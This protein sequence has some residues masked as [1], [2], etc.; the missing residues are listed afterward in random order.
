MRKAQSNIAKLL[1]TFWF[2]LNSH[3]VSY[4]IETVYD[5]KGKSLSSIASTSVSD[6][7]KRHSIKENFQRSSQLILACNVG[8]QPNMK[9]KNFCGSVT[10][11]FTE[12]TAKQQLENLVA[13]IML[14]S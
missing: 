7:F 10:D 5:G 8:R 13:K 14:L 2:P 6:R 1:N 4:I 9:V 12:A 11:C 3:H